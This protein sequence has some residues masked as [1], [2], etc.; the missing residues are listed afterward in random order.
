MKPMWN[1][2][3]PSPAGSWCEQFQGDNLEVSFVVCAF[4]WL[5]IVLIRCRHRNIREFLDPLWK[6]Y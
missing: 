3:G 5:E 4:I 1:G 2:T 6:K